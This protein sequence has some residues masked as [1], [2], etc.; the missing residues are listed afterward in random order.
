MLTTDILI[1][2]SICIETQGS[3]PWQ[4][5][6]NQKRGG[7]TKSVTTDPD[8]KRCILNCGINEVYLDY[9][10]HWFTNSHFLLKMVS[11]ISMMMSLAETLMYY[12]GIYKHYKWLVATHTIILRL[13][14]KCLKLNNWQKKP[15]LER[16]AIL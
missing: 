16:S 8:N 7:G 3:T 2:W 15:D 11:S 14:K 9:D 1:T 12:S 5:L 6:Y 13:G 4:S 10:A